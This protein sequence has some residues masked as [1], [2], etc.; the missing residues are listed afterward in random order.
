MSMD[1]Y[2][3]YRR[4]RVRDMSLVRGVAAEVDPVTRARELATHFMPKPM[5]DSMAEHQISRREHG[6]R[7]ASDVYG[8]SR[9]KPR[10]HQSPYSI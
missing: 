8:A 5:P 6:I 9:P 3:A 10:S 1:D 4:G 7:D 2:A